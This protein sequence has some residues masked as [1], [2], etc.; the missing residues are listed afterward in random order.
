MKLSSKTYK[1]TEANGPALKSAG[2]AVIGFIACAVAM[3]NDRSQFFHSY[4]T[5]FMFW[6]SLAL[7][8]LF[9]TMLHHLTGARWSVVLRRISETIMATLPLFAVL[10][11]PLLFGLHDLFHWTHEEAVA[12]DLLL[13]KKAPYLNIP[14]FIVR[15][16]AYFGVWLLLAALLYKSSIFQD[17]EEPGDHGNRWRC[18][19]APGMIAFALTITYAAFDWMMSLDP[20]WFSTIY[21]VYF[22]A[23]SMLSV[24]AFLVLIL[25]YLR[26]QDVLH[27]EV[28]VEHYHDLGKLLFGFIVFWSYIAFSQYFL[29]WYSNI[30]EETV[31]FTHRWEGSWKYVSML[32]I[33]GHFVFPFLALLGRDAKR[34]IKFLSMMAIWILFIHFVD[35]YWL[36]HPTHSHHGVHLS[37]IDIVPMVAIGGA[38]L[39]CFWWRLTSQPVVPVGDPYLETSMKF[40]NM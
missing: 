28:T 39:W 21:G 31:W 36:I 12:A 23:G 24:L 18:I 5:A 17:K 25:A 22:F 10:F 38:T 37:W 1:L 16:L 2:V 9:F 8:G 27:N 14:F 20:H 32:I 11:I 35:L 33:F 34:N 7:G 3:Y 13:Q 6:L 19:S 40:E 15:A 29:I 4:L 30:P 26:K